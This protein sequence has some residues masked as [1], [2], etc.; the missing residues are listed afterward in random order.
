MQNIGKPTFEVVNRCAVL[1][2]LA[3]MFWVQPFF[4]GGNREG[5]MPMDDRK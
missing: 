3:D 5:A 4:G 1:Q 2:T